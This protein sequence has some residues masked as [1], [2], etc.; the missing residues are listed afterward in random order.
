MGVCRF[1]NIHLLDVLRANLK[2]CGPSY[3]ISL[4]SAKLNE[5]LVSVGHVHT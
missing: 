4:K 1:F 5:Y 2:K 3:L